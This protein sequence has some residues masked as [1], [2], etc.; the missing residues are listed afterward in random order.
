VLQAHEAR[1]L[2]DE[3]PLGLMYAM[4]RGARIHDGPDEVLR[5]VV[6]RRVL[7]VRRRRALALRLSC[8]TGERSGR[9]PRES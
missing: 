6:A 9:S 4:A 2:T 1:G 5:M 8:A 3:T 7:V